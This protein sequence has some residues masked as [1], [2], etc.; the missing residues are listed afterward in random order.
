MSGF[1][2]KTSLTRIAWVPLC[3]L[4]AACHTDMYD[5]PRYTANQPSDFFEDGRAM[6]PPPAN[7]VAMGTFDPNSAMFTGRL[8]GDL[9]V[10]LP[11]ELT[12]ELLAHGETRY[13]AFC[14]P[15]HG[16]T[17][18]GNGIAAYRGGMVVPSLHNDRLRTVPVGYYFDVITN[19]LNRMYSYAHRLPPEDRWA[20]AAYVRALQLSQH[21]PAETL[22]AEDRAQ[23]P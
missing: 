7:T 3:L 14:A 2:L 8:D 5:Q 22:P 13:N 10:E 6:R 12:A 4:L 15:C 20:V 9:T 11:M 21:T 19:G 1:S 18:E 23:L 17:G 16:L